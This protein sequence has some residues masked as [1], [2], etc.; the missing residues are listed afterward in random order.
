MV[1]LR[2]P[3]S[4]AP[5]PRLDAV[6]VELRRRWLIIANQRRPGWCD[7]AEDAVQAGLI[8][9]LLPV[10]L[11][12]VQDPSRIEQF[13]AGLF[14]K[15]FLALGR[16]RWRELRR[17]AP[18]PASDVDAMER[19]LQQLVATDPTPEDLASARERLQIVTECLAGLEIARAKFF[20][21]M[22]DR[23]LATRF[24]K[25]HD[26]IRNHLKRVRHMLRLRLENGG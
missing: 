5:D 3:A 7:E 24:G 6:L 2:S 12:R 8:D 11:D 4:G 17:R 20:E 13:A 22:L 14:W 16:R 10:T 15:K 26:A 18:E 1:V 19:L 9:I 21:G 25:S 23:D